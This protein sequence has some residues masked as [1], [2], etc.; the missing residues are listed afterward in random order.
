MHCDEGWLDLDGCMDGMLDGCDEGWLDGCV[1]GMLDSCDEGWLLFEKGHLLSR[2]AFYE[3]I[4]KK[5]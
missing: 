1:D 5:L 2:K 4:M 3:Q